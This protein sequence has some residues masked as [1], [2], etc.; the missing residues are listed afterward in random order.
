MVGSQEVP[1]ITGHFGL[2]V[3]NKAGQRL[4]EFAK[5]TRGQNE[6]LPETREMTL[7]MDIT[8]W[9][10]PNQIDYILCSQRWRRSIQSAQTRQGADYG[11][12]HEL[13]MAKFRP[14]LKTVG[15]TTRPFR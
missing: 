5:R 4:T 12:D 9:P 11:S 1:G 2:E 14:K 8:R 13:L 15:N 7:H 6:N 3:K 10:I